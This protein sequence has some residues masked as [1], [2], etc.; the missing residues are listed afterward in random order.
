MSSTIRVGS[1]FAQDQALRVRVGS[2]RTSSSL[3]SMLVPALIIHDGDLKFKG[4]HDTH[5]F[6]HPVLLLGACLFH[7]LTRYIFAFPPFSIAQQARG[8]LS[9]AQQA[10]GLGSAQIHHRVSNL[11]P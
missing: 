5:D 11:D 6:K 3:T 1:S 9:I 2:R 7:S 10:R 8:L 4:I